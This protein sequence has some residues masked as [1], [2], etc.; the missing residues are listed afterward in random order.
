MHYGVKGGA[1]ILLDPPES[2][3]APELRGKPMVFFRLATDGMVGDARLANRSGNTATQQLL[4]RLVD[5]E[6][7]TSSGVRRGSDV[8]A[9]VTMGLGARS[10]DRPGEQVIR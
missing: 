5:I 8:D 6:S 1:V 4:P 10:T 3:S 9:I 2:L 7:L